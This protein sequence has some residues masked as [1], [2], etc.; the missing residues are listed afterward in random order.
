[1]G[2]STQLAARCTQLSCSQVPPVSPVVDRYGNVFC[3]PACLMR[4]W[5][6]EPPEPPEYRAAWRRAG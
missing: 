5:D 2:R 4:F 1:M 6:N 3:G